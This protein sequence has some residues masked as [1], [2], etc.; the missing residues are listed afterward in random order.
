[1]NKLSTWF[2]TNRLSVN[3]SK[4]N[5]MIFDR[6][7]QPGHHRVYIDNIVIERVNC[8][9]LKSMVLIYKI[10]NNL[11][12]SNILSYFCMVHTTH[13]HDTRQAGHFKMCTVELR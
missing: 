2:K 5:C 1:M 7:N 4:R 11:M 13:D 10:Y 12:P 9:T 8:N 3:V 6:S